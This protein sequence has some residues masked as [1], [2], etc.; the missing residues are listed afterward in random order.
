MASSSPDEDHRKIL[1]HLSGL[2]EILEKTETHLA[3]ISSEEREAKRKEVFQK[4]MKEYKKDI[5][6]EAK[7]VSDCS[8]DESENTDP[9]EAVGSGRWTTENLQQKLQDM[10]EA[11]Q[12]RKNLMEG[13]SLEADKQREPSKISFTFEEDGRHALWQ[14]F[15]IQDSRE[16]EKDEASEKHATQCSEARVTDSEKGWKA[17]EKPITTHI[18]IPTLQV[19]RDGNE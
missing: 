3:G 15:N 18:N 10:E 17:K 2:E 12:R 16:E 14:Q 1:E 7:Q 6:T 4:N 19:R 13:A 5:G 8:D 9:G 11:R